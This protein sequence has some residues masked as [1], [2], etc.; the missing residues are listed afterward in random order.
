MRLG[1]TFHA[2]THRDFPVCREFNGVADEV[3]QDL[4]QPS[5]TTAQAYVNVG[6]DF[7]S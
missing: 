7:A 3:Y 1:L 2:D 6:S 4:P 5:W